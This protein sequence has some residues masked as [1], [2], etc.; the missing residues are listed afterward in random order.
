MRYA[1]K[2][3]PPAGD[4][5]FQSSLLKLDEQLPNQTNY[6]HLASEASLEARDIFR[7]CAREPERKNLWWYEPCRLAPSN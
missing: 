7:D 3:R 5:G 4:P 1:L 2:S 6:P